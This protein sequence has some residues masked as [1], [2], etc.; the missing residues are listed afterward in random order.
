[1]KYMLLLASDPADEPMP[2][3]EAFGHYM[4][5]WA[6][7]SQAL[8]E[9]GAMVGGEALE[10]PETASTVRIR[11]GK[12]LVTDG[13][14]IESKEVVGGF[15][16]IECDTRNEAIE[17]AKKIPLREDRTVEVGRSGRADRLA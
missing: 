15:Y 6:A 9:A 8:A 7:Y 14:Y 13:P 2:D 16:V 3:S 1:M 12:R 10:A 17:W 11:D 5:E 4:E